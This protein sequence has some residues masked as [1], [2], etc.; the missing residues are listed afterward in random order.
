[1]TIRSAGLAT[2]LLALAS[3]AFA[4]APPP[5]TARYEVL[6]NG[7]PTG[8]ATISFSAGADGHYQLRTITSGTSGLAALTGLHVEETSVLSWRGQQPE[9]LRYDYVQKVGWKS[10][11]RH[12]RVDPASQRIDYQ[13][14]DRD[15]SPTYRS[16][17]LDR[18]AITVALMQDAALGKSGDLLF[19]VPDKD[20]LQPWHYRTGATSM[21]Q[22]A[23]GPQPGL[24]VD[25]I[26]DDDSGRKTTLWLA[27][28]RGFVP[29]RL[30]QSEDNGETIELRI[31]SL[32]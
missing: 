23:L 20:S 25:R 10:R 19:W 8:E 6:R 4:A 16:G 3:S 2:L 12:L 17:V 18:H 22:T 24:R 28:G 27:T 13:D 26:R 9:T 7:D 14:K 31:T 32:R 29:L 15:Y 30:I 5:F 21:L 1:M 11:E